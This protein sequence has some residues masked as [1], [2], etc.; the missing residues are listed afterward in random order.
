MRAARRHLK[1]RLPRDL[2]AIAAQKPAGLLRGRWEASVVRRANAVGDPNGTRTR[3]FGVRGRRPRPL[4]DGAG[5]ARRPYGGNPEW[6]Q[7]E[8]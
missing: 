8:P 6:A 2:S 5:Q 1:N 3:V 7:E 4:D